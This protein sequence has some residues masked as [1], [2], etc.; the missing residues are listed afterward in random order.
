MRVTMNP[1]IHSLGISLVIHRRVLPEVHRGVVVPDGFLRILAH[2]H[3]IPMTTTVGWCLT[4]CGC[5][6]YHVVFLP[7]PMAG[8]TIFRRFTIKH[9][10]IS[11][12]EGSSDGTFPTRSV[13]HAPSHTY[14]H[15][16]THT[17]PHPYPSISTYILSP[18][19]Q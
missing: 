5:G 11:N 14:T 1:C 3:R 4:M 8:P 15:T 17:H 2:H 16:H 12:V 19:T 13:I 9:T 10:I 18:V 7:T 6:E